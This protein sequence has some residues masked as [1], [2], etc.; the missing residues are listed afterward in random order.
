MQRQTALLQ[1][2]NRTSQYRYQTEYV[3]RMRQQQVSYARDANY[4]Y[5][6]DPYYYTAPIYRYSRGGSY[7]ETN[8]YG[9]DFLR[10]AVNQGYGEG[11]HAGRADRQDHWRSNYRDSYAYRDANY[12][13]YGRYVNQDE[14]NYYF[15]QGFRR[16]YEDGYASRYRYGSYSNGSYAML[17]AFLGQILDF[18]S[19][20]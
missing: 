20:H 13:Y 10:R 16:G 18:R 19:I 7:Y 14:Y 4:D 9:A 11:F 6:R 17:G 15:R 5:G 8:Q 1:Q 12:G 2:Q 3:E